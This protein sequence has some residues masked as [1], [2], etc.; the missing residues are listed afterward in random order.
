MIEE[1]KVWVNGTFDVFHAGHLSLL[2]F[3]SRLGKL[4]VGVDSDERVREL[5]GETR[6]IFNLSQRIRMLAALK[7]VHRVY[8]FD[9]D[10]H[11]SSIIEIIS[12]D[13]FVI[14][15]DYREKPIIG[16]EHAKEIV[17]FERIEGISSSRIIETLKEN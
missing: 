5:K 13:F 17:Y 8:A 2:E 14:G 10:Q 11:L 16:S 6:P 3:A 15:S 1:K 9:S 7:C 12:P 4:H